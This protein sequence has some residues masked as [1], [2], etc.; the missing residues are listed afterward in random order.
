MASA[1]YLGHCCPFGRLQRLQHAC[2]QLAQ[3]CYLTAERA[4]VELATSKL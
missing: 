2:E 1:T 3:S 4:G